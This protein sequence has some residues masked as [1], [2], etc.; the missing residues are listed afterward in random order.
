MLQLFRFE[1]LHTKWCILSC[2][3]VIHAIN[4]K[5]HNLMINICLNEQS[6]PLPRYNYSD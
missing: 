1:W 3:D 2:I 4:M 5:H 6:H